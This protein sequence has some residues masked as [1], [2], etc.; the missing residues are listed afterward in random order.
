MNQYLRTLK[1]FPQM[2]QDDNILNHFLDIL[3]NHKPDGF[4]LEDK[5]I[6][7]MNHRVDMEIQKQK[8]DS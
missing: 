7:I 4:E 5:F 3:E 6:E 8:Y 2:Q 1:H